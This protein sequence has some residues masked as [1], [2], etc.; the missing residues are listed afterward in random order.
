MHD[1][2]FLISGIEVNHDLLM[3]YCFRDPFFTEKEAMHSKLNKKVDQNL[4]E[5]MIRSIGER[6]LFFDYQQ[7]KSYIGQF[8]RAGLHS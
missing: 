2:L 4:T 5:T 7:L 8:T 1:L 3:N 6:F